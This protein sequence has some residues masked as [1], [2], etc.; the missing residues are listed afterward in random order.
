MVCNYWFTVHGSVGI[1]ENCPLM[2]FRRSRAL[3]NQQNHENSHVKKPNACNA[4]IRSI[5]TGWCLTLILALLSNVIAVTGLVI[6]NI[7]EFS[8]L[9][10]AF[11]NARVALQLRVKVD[12]LYSMAWPSNGFYCQT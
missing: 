9:C 11:E 4:T 3:I 6:L 1:G 12:K 10:G 7:M 5:C 2:P 8:I